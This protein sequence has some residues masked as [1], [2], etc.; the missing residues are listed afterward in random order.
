MTHAILIAVGPARVAHRRGR[1]AC[2]WRMSTGGP[3]RC[4]MRGKG[5]P[6]RSA[7]AAR[8]GRAGAGEYLSRRTAAVR[9]S[10]GVRHR[11]GPA[12]AAADRDG[13][14]SGRR[15]GLRPGRACPGWARTGCGTRWPVTCCA[16]APPLAQIGQVLRH[17]TQ[18]TTAIYAKVDHAALRELARPW[19]GGAAMSALRARPPRSTWRCAARWGSSCAR[20]TAADE[21]RRLLRRHAAATADHRDWRWRGPDH[22]AHATRCGG[23]RRLMVVRVFARHLAALRPGAP[24]SRRPT[25][26][27]APTG[28]STPVPVLPERD[29]RVD[30]S[31]RPRCAPPLRGGDLR[32][33]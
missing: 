8:G 18:L 2:G 16:P 23:P 13:G 25:C 11:A 28:G 10:V 22:P 6:G 17:R 15:A 1:S 29:R 24:R 31:R 30:A 33:R 7:A 12:A 27:R 32:R 26:C 5:Q 4:S 19:P 3:G 9:R 14:A 20:R 21:L